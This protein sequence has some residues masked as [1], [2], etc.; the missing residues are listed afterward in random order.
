MRNMMVWIEKSNHGSVLT[1]YQSYP[2]GIKKMVRITELDGEWQVDIKGDSKSI[3]APDGDVEQFIDT[4]LGLDKK[5]I[6]V[7]KKAPAMVF[8]GSKFSFDCYLDEAGGE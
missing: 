5:A 4:M 7:D 8:K 6:E 3:P 2:F 1:G